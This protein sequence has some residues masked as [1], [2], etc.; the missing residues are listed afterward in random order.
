MVNQD[1][2]TKLKK[3]VLGGYVRFLE[4]IDPQVA[5]H[6]LNAQKELFLAGERFFSEEIK[7]ADKALNK[8]RKRQEAPA[9][10]AASPQSTDIV[11]P[12]STPHQS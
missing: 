5:T 4:S 12:E 10:A 6:V 11:P 8:I 7:H 3:N 1:F 2:A 9:E